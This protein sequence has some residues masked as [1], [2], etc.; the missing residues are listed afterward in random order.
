[1]SEAHEARAVRNGVLEQWPLSPDRVESQKYSSL[2][3]CMFLTFSQDFSKR[4]SFIAIPLHLLLCIFS[5][6]TSSPTGFW[7][8]VSFFQLRRLLPNFCP[9][10]AVVS[11]SSLFSFCG[12]S[13]YFAFFC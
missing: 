5:A 10:L 3:L 7:S 9:F 11:I 8:V 13:A 2:P 6:N 12:V 4:D 1:M